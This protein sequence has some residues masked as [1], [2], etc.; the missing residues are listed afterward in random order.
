MPDSKNAKTPS[1]RP[2]ARALHWIMAVLIVVQ[3][4]FGKIM[5]FDGPE[6]NLWATLTETYSLYDLHKLLG[7]TLLG[8]V[9]LRLANRIARDVPPDDPALEPWQ[10]A[11][12]TLVHAWIYLLLIVVPLLGWIGVSLY[13]ALTL[14]DSFQLPAL[15]HANK[16]ASEPVLVAHAFA[17]YALIALAFAHVGAALFHH[18]IRRDETLRRMLP[19]RR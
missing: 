19:G 13:P 6:P 5:V 16:P 7:V 17:A 11:A 14:F 3:V 8:L 9:L 15:V 10:R 12:A 1:Y 4:V 18:F 2:L